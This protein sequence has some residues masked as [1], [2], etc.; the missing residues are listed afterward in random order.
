MKAIDDIQKILDALNIRDISISE[1]DIK[2]LAENF[3]KNYPI[4]E[5]RVFV[6]I[7]EDCIKK[8]EDLTSF[9]RCV[10]QKIYNIY[11]VQ[12]NRGLGE[13]CDRR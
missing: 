2:K 11:E 9:K 5:N 12:R 4:I 1:S 3:S 8:S 10:S 6:K 7:I 13:T